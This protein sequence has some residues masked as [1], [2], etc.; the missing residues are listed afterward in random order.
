MDSS[1]IVPPNDVETT[2]TRLLR[3]A[4]Q[5]DNAAWRQ[6]VSLYGPVVRFWIRRSGLSGSDLADVFQE[7]FIAV[8]RNI[9]K[10]ERE[11]GRAKFRAWLKTVAT[12]KT[13]D[14]FRRVAKRPEAYGGTTAVQKLGHIE[15]AVE[16]IDESDDEALAL[17]E[18]AF[19]AQ[20]MLEIV[21]K[22][23]RENTWNA[24]Y[25]T[26]IDGLNATEVAEELGMTPVAVRKSKSRVLKRLKEALGSS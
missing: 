9:E 4:A 3:R 18:D 24:F 17:S 20:R 10:F 11:P 7:V 8:A 26:A 19:L 2:S 22:E 13:N 6:L 21:H 12:S 5:H 16:L 15:A 1:K 14:H 25:R 23:F